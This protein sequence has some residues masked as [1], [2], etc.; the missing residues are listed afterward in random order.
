MCFLWCN[1]NNNWSHVRFNCRKVEEKSEPRCQLKVKI[2]SQYKSW[3]IVNFVSTCSL[4]HVLCFSSPCAE[5]GRSGLQAGQFNSW[6]CVIGNHLTLTIKAL[7][8]EDIALMAAKVALNFFFQPLWWLGRSK[9]LKKNSAYATHTKADFKQHYFHT[10]QIVVLF[11]LHNSLFFVNG[12]LEVLL[13]FTLHSWQPIEDSD[14]VST[15]TFYQQNTPNTWVDWFKLVWG[16]KQMMP[17]VQ[18]RVRNWNEK[19]WDKEHG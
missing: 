9:R 14:S 11:R 19:Q 5:C 6:L 7:S 4:N 2:Y 15:T 17:F 16:K 12:S 8:E 18:W 3:I 1:R 13:L 10:E